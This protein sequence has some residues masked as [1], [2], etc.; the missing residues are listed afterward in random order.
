[1]A[2]ITQSTEPPVTPTV[3]K[4]NTANYSLD[5]SQGTTKFPYPNDS[6]RLGDYDYYTNLF[7]GR[8]FEAFNVRINNMAYGEVYNKLRYVKA[9]LA[10]LISKVCADM[11]FSEP[12]KIVVDD[13]DQTFVDELVKENNF[14]T[15]LYESAL[16]NSYMGDDCFKLRVGSRFPTVKPNDKT[17]IIEEFTPKIYFPKTNQ[18]NVRQEPE[19]VELAWTFTLNNQKYLRKE[20]HTLGKVITKVFRMKENTIEAEV[21][22]SILNEVGLEPEVST[23]VEEMLIVHIPNWKTG[24]RYFGFSDYF[25]LDALFYAINN[26]LTKIDNILDKHSDPILAIPEGV[27][28]EKGNV[29]KEKLG[30]LQIPAGAGPNEKP[31]YIIWNASLEA[32][33]K[34]IEKLVEM[35]FMVSET[36]PDVL[37]MGQGQSDSGRALKLKLLRTIA[38][39]QR[40]KLY[41]DHAIKDIIYKAQVLAKQ[42]NLEVNGV[43]LTKAPVMPE[44]VWADGLPVDISEAIDNEVKAIDAGITSE[45][46]AVARVYG[47]DQ[48]TA[49]Q[50]IKEIKDA[51]A[52]AMP[53]MNTGVN[54]LGNGFGKKPAD[55]AVPDTKK[56][57]DA[58]AQK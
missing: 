22:I 3:G 34:E 19:T 51:K 5:T 50:K 24:N 58:N 8:H 55:P 23:G 31:E 40:K 35:F 56:Q 57:Q 28:D 4:A 2:E 46:D 11:L 42:W 1:M 48:D 10:G 25:D 7:E 32:A 43:K 41:Y 27:L 6:T 49:E 30:M 33:F 26:R 17:V 45:E 13:G 15:Q 53:I 47:Y 14:L 9:N 37:G 29:K 16:S 44:I 21:D 38:K 12:V 36:S 18:F 20:I 39:V 52:I 54:P